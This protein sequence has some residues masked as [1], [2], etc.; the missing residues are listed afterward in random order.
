MDHFGVFE[1]WTGLNDREAEGEFTWVDG[2]PLD[3]E[4]WS[5]GAPAPEGPDCV[6]SSPEGWRDSPCEEPGAFVCRGG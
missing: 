3:F 2:T 4:R 5:G 1:S 6:I